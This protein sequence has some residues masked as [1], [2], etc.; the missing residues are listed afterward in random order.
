MHVYAGLLFF[1]ASRSL[2]DTVSSGLEQSE[3][4]RHTDHMKGDKVDIEV[5]SFHLD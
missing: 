2:N 4:Q 3:K 5:G 1:I